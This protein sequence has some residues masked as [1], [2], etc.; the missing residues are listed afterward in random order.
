[1]ES[2]LLSRR[3]LGIPPHNAY[4][5]ETATVHYRWHPLF[6]QSVRVIKRRKLWHEEYLTCELEDHT[7]RSLPSW[8]FNPECAQFSLGRPMAAVAALSELRDLL[9]SLQNPPQYGKASLKPLPE[10]DDCEAAHTRS[11]TQPTVAERDTSETFAGRPAGTGP[12]SG[13][14]ARAGRPR[15]HD[16]D[17]E[18]RSA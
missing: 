2:L 1:M 3:A 18:R 9:D 12:G 15:R 5:L 4:V 14:P 16:G 11:A 10:E 8:M 6:G 17:A 13:R 7:L